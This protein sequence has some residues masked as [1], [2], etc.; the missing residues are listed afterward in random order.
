MNKH[1][2]VNT[3][4][5]TFAEGFVTMFPLFTSLSSEPPME[6]TMVSTISVFCTSLFLLWP[7]L[8]YSRSSWHATIQPTMG[9]KPPWQTKVLISL[10][11]NQYAAGSPSREDFTDWM[12]LFTR[13]TA[14]DEWR[15]GGENKDISDS[16]PVCCAGA[17]GVEEKL[18][19]FFF[20]LKVT[21]VI[22]LSLQSNFFFLIAD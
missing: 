8:L 18:V 22:F 10:I 15:D 1:K 21:K 12:H 19:L 7:L 11:I 5:G 13:S 3:R 2:Q 20:L 17:N 4:P 9:Q 14:R 16:C 6:I